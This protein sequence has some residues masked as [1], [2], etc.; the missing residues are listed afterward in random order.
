MKDTKRICAGGSDGSSKK[1]CN[2]VSKDAEFVLDEHALEKL[3]PFLIRIHS[4]LF[5]HLP[6]EIDAKIHKGICQR[7]DNAFI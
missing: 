6:E 4:V 1:S 5:F 2:C 7:R 3:I